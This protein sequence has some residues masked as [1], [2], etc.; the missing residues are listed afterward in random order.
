MA[1]TYS[2]D[3]EADVRIGD[4]IVSVRRKG[5]SEVVQAKIVASTLDDSG[6]PTILWL[7]RLIHASH[8]SVIGGH[9]VSGAFVTELTLS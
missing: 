2:H 3:V 9:S 4:G 6:K 5:S 8:E 1:K 7:D